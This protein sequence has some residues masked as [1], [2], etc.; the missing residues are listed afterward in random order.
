MRTVAVGYLN[1][2][3]FFPFHFSAVVCISRAHLIV[4]MNSIGTPAPGGF[5]LPCNAKGKELNKIC[6]W[7]GATTATNATVDVC[8]PNAGRPY[9]A[10]ASLS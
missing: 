3:C 10:T 1:V 5:A 4:D 8:N 2:L 9:N 7:N 6:A